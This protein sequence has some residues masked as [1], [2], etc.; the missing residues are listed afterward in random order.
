[1]LPKK[2]ST[3]TPSLVE[4]GLSSFILKNFKRKIQ[5]SMFNNSCSEQ[6]FILG[7]ILFMY[8]H[9]QDRFIRL[10]YLSKGFTKTPDVAGSA[11]IK[12]IKKISLLIASCFEE[13]IPDEADRDYAKALLRELKVD[14]NSPKPSIIYPIELSEVLSKYKLK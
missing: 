3:F 14:I 12:R 5:R 11:A 6:A 10:S 8:G 13:A 1:M 4:Y 2:T 9:L 7:V